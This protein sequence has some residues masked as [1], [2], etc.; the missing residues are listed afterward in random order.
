MRY[1]QR[2]T[3]TVTLPSMDT[4]GNKHTV[5]VDTMQKLYEIVIT[6]ISS[7]QLNSV[8]E[9][10]IRNIVDRLDPQYTGDVTAIPTNGWLEL[11]DPEFAF[12]KKK[13]EAP[14]QIWFGSFDHHPLVRAVYEDWKNPT[15]TK[16]LGLNRE[17]RSGAGGKK[18][19][20]VLPYNAQKAKPVP[21]DYAAPSDVL[22][23][24]MV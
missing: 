8:D 24:A 4:Q 22:D 11:S 12:L 13:V 20:N 21:N 17:V 10:I 7:E 15:E 14:K 9:S 2:K 18:D 3:V 5:T 6:P 19:K 23:E 16:P 1:I